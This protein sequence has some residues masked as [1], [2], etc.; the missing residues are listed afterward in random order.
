MTDTET[1]TNYTAGLRALADLLDN[2]P[3]LPL[4]YT[5]INAASPITFYVLDAG[6]DPKGTLAKIARLLPGTVGKTTSGSG[7]YFSIT[8]TLAGLHIDATA[9]R[10]AVCERVVTGTREV[11]VPATRR[12]TVPARPATVET[13]EDVEWVC[14]PLLADADPV[15][16]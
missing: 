8:G 12:I 16:A 4:P 7:Q 6:E 10:K 15:S 5:G 2:N 14:S 13:V 1:R 11:I 3:D 9:Y